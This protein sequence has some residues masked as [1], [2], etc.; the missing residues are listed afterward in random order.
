MSQPDFF[1]FSGHS[2]KQQKENTIHSQRMMFLLSPFLPIYILYT[3][4]IISNSS[5]LTIQRRHTREFNGIDYMPNHTIKILNLRETNKK[6]CIELDKSRFRTNK[7]QLGQTIE[8]LNIVGLKKHC[9][10]AHPKKEC[11]CNFPHITFFT[12]IKNKNHKVI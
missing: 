2:T 12:K 7:N 11:I 8:D 5:I 6:K 10:C 3:K 9:I 1:D 4:H